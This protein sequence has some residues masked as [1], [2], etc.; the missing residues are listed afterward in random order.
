[1]V[2]QA[3]ENHCPWLNYDGYFLECVCRIL[4][5]TVERKDGRGVITIKDVGVLCML[6]LVLWKELEELRNSEMRELVFP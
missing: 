4:E 1:L 3:I 6:S 2:I 5:W